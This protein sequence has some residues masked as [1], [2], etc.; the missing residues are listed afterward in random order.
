MVDNNDPFSS[1][2][3]RHVFYP[4]IVSDGT[5]GYRVD[6]DLLNVNNITVSGNIA[7]PSGT[8]SGGGT[9]PTGPQG[10]QGIT[11]A[12]GPTGLQGPQGITG[13]TGPTGLQGPTGPTGVQG[14]TGPDGNAGSM[15]GP[16]G[17]PSSITGPTGPPLY[18][19]TLVGY[20]YLTT[21]GSA[22]FPIPLSTSRI[23][24]KMKGGA[25]GGAG[26][27]VSSGA[28]TQGGAGGSGQYVVAELFLT[29][30]LGNNK[31]QL[32]YSV[33]GGGSAGGTSLPGGN[34]GN[35]TV[36]LEYYNPLTSA[37]SPLNYKLGTLYTLSAEGGYGGTPFTP[38]ASLFGIGGYGGGYSDTSRLFGMAVP[39]IEGDS[40]NTIPP[41]DLI[42]NRGYDGAGDGGVNGFPATSGISGSIYIYCYSI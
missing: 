42:L 18:G 16:T 25:G 23:V 27:Y 17:P 24:L 40:T 13:Y 5:G 10:L 7:G 34:G 26:D 33:G 21:S 14:N 2:L 11:G 4:K 6:V 12:T 9:G 28:G 32:S 20:Q 19:Q 8:F 3:L 36:S 29:N 15:T 37:S 30:P 31:F 35:T 41:Y 39:G 1:N 38:V 22:S